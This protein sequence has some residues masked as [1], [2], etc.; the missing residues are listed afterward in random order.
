MNCN[1]I[2]KAFI[3]VAN[4]SSYT[5][6]KEHSFL[7][8]SS[9]LIQSDHF[10]RRWSGNIEDTK[11]MFDIRFCFHHKTFM[12]FSF[13]FLFSNICTEK[14][15]IEEAIFTVFYAIHWKWETCRKQG[16]ICYKKEQLL[17]FFSIQRNL[18]ILLFSSFLHN[19][20]S[21]HSVLVCV[22]ICFFYGGSF[23]SVG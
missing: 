2:F 4:Q 5:P 7:F 20:F 8:E 21:K 19:G 17:F 3:P 18:N 23:L 22:V 14:V 13:C 16:G 9:T 10:W 6:M 11:G 12:L 15:K 1:W